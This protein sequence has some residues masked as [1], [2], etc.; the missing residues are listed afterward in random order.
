[1]GL[2]LVTQGPRVEEVRDVR[3]RL[4]GRA[5]RRIDLVGVVPHAALVDEG[6]A[7]AAFRVQREVAVDAVVLSRCEEARREDLRVLDLPRVLRKRLVPGR[8]LRT[9]RSRT[10]PELQLVAV[11]PPAVGRVGRND[12]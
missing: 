11:H 12:L 6:L 3:L 4:T 2:Q 10:A 9:R 1:A 7:V 5:G 8:L